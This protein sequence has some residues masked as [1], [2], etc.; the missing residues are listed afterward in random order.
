ME[1]D[2]K[3]LRADLESTTVRLGIK[4]K[5]WRVEGIVFPHVL[6]YI[7]AAPVPGGPTGFLLLSECR[8]YPGIAPTSQLWHGGNDGPLAKQHRPNVIAFSDHNSGLYLP[9]DRLNRNHSDWE[10]KH[11]DMLWKPTMKIDVLL[12]TVYDL[13]NCADYPGA[14]LPADALNVPERF[15]A[16]DTA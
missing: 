9:I 14:V 3:A 13:L 6:F 8:G 2:E 16:K 5:K 4:R 1:L 11:A 7:A 12:E 15:V 10:T